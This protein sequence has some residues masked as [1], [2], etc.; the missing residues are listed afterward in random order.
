MFPWRQRKVCV[1]NGHLVLRTGVFGKE[2]ISLADVIRIEAENRDAVTYDEIVVTFLDVNGKLICIS[3]LDEGYERAIES[4][5]L[6]FPNI[7][8]LS[9]LNE[10]GPFE[11]KSILIWE[12]TTGKG[13]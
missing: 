3:E 7:A 10:C 8:K 5:R 9:S 11:K 2:S 6:M 4:V 12:S 13:L 1:D